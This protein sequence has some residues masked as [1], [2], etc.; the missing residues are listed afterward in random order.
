MLKNQ[1]LDENLNNSQ[2]V[3]VSETSV[4]GKLQT[5]LLPAILG[6]LSGMTT[7]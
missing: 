4:R 3:V 7:E 1:E 5:D 2:R 6:H